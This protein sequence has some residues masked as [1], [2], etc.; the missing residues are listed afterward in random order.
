MCSQGA[1]AAGHR[2]GKKD[3]S[4]ITFFFPIFK[5]ERGR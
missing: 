4:A 1:A 3:E 5:D 2:E